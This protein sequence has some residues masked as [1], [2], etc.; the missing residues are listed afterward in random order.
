MGDPGGAVPFDRLR[1]GSTGLRRTPNAAHHERGLDEAGPGGGE[2]G[3]GDPVE[4][5]SGVEEETGPA[6]VAVFG[7]EGA[8]GGGVAEAG[9]GSRRAGGQGLGG[10]GQGWLPG[11]AW[12]RCGGW[13]HGSGRLE[14][15]PYEE[16]RTD[17]G[18]RGA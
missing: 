7:L 3:G 18:R 2:D 9:A 11:V 12:L 10:F 16:T 17:R 15:G 8:Q 6:A 13:V 14:T 5:G 4:E 1:A